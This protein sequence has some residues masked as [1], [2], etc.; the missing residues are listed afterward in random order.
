[1]ILVE[2]FDYLKFSLDYLF[3]HFLCRILY[4]FSIVLYLH[5]VCARLFV[6][7]YL[8]IFLTIYLLTGWAL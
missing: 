6:I 5:I 8:I 7:H 4:Y 2:T 1:M 3:I